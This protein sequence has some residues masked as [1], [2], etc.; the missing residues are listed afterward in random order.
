MSR[1]PLKFIRH[2]LRR[3]MRGQGKRRGGMIMGAMA[4]RTGVSLE[5]DVV[6]TFGCT[7]EDA[8]EIKLFNQ[9]EFN[10]YRKQRE[11]GNN[12]DIAAKTAFE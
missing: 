12:H 2:D 8:E 4:A 1:Y 10:I 3:T 5:L 6:A 11:A 9:W 7:E